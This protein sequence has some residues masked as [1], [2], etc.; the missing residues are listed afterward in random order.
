[1]NTDLLNAF[2]DV[3]ETA[4]K[5]A[6]SLAAENDATVVAARIEEIIKR[7]EKV[8]RDNDSAYIH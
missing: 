7:R 6:R 1:M 2:A 8:K 5:L 3:L 4:S